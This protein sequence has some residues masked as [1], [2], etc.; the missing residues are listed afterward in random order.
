MWSKRFLSETGI[1]CRQAPNRKHFS[2]LIGWIVTL[3]PRLCKDY[4]LG[5]AL[6]ICGTVNKEEVCRFHCGMLQSYICARYEEIRLSIIFYSPLDLQSICSKI[7]CQGFESFPPT[8]S[9]KRMGALCEGRTGSDTGADSRNRRMPHIGLCADR[10]GAHKSLQGAERTMIS[11]SR[12]P[13]YLACGATDMIL[14]PKR[15]Y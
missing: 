15:M 12:K 3:R 10:S 4:L 1:S 5:R 8:F 13:C 14:F 2:S 11:F 6:K 7:I 9:S